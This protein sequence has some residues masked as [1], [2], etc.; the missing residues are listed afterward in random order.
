MPKHLRIFF[1]WKKDD[2]EAKLLK[3]QQSLQYMRHSEAEACVHL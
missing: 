2:R 3:S 1:Y